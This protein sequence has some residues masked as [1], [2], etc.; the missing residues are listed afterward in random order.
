VPTRSAQSSARR[1]SRATVDVPVVGPRQP[2]PCGSGKRYKACHGKRRREGAREFVTRPFAGLPGEGD[3]IALREIISAATAPV[4]LAESHRDRSVLVAT[5][6]P[7][8]VPALVRA[9]GQ[10]VLALQTTEASADPSADAARALRAALDAEPGS[11]IQAEPPV[12]DGPRL[13]DL[14]DPTSAFPVTVHEAF[15][16]WLDGTD[17]LGVDARAAVEQANAAISPAARLASVDAGYWCRIGDREQVRWVMPYEEEPLLDGLARLHA[18]SADGLGTGTRLLGTF[19]A[20]GRLVPVWDLRTGT[21]VED[22]EEPAAALAAR[23]AEALAVS[24]PLSTDERR[25]RSG[26]ANRQVTIR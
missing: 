11:T 19:R 15:D 17:F 21:P 13:Q 23:L 1:P 14:L 7:M 5:L 10:I 4:R 25:A 6:L 18:R 2:C 9:D 24:A 16:F 20:L 8:A 12:P 22:V 3:W 26:L